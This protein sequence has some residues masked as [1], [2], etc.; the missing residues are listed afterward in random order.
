MNQRFRSGALTRA[1]ARRRSA[2]AAIFIVAMTLAAL[3]AMGVYGMSATAYDVR[4][5]GHGRAAA[6]SQQAAGTA[7][8]M[9]SSILASANASA[10]ESTMMPTSAASSL[11]KKCLTAKPITAGT[12]SADLDTVAKLKNAEACWAFTVQDL[13][14][15][16]SDQTNFP[17]GSSAPF[18][19]GSFGAL[20]TELPAL[21]R[22]RI[23]I[24]NPVD[25]DAP[26]GN[27]IGGVGAAPKFR[28]LRVTVFSEMR[29]EPTTGNFG[30]AESIAVGRGRIVIGPF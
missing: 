7:L 30:R 5:A 2:G 3:A 19:P 25:W 28:Q 9:T 22:T 24:T 20:P 6:Q 13:K 11:T 29:L 26:S 17:T 27:Q 16:S 1:R 18:A 21:P 10:I 23:E 12:T 4:G 15:F 14:A 8:I